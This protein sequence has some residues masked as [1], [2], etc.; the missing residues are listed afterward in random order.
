[1]QLLG[2]VIFLCLA[3]TGGYY[4][5]KVTQKKESD[6]EWEAKVRRMIRRTSLTQTQAK[7]A[8]IAY[9]KYEEEM[10]KRASIR[11]PDG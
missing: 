3:V 10:A 1:M 6:R 5:G 4:L 11:W 2:E 7:L 8:D 9:E